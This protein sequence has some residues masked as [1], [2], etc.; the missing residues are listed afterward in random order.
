MAWSSGQGLST[1]T[2]YIPAQAMSLDSGT[3]AVVGAV[4][5]AVNVVAL[6]DAATQGAAFSFAIPQD[7]ASGNLTCAPVWAPGATDGTAHTVR[8]SYDAKRNIALG[9]ISAAGTTT[10][11]TGNSLA[12]TANQIVFDA[13][14]GLGIGSTFVAND[15]IRMNIRR[16]GADGADTYVGVVNL[17]GCLIA[18]TPLF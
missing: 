18:Y 10:A 15:I 8:W 16:V 3:A 14:T 6:A 7:W 9:D 12:R 4:P 13:A 2:L 1:R 11:W 5:D 17:I